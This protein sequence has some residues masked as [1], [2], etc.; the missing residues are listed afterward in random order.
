MNVARFR[1]MCGRVHALDRDK[2]LQYSGARHWRCTHC[3]RRFV[4][5]HERSD[6][7]TPIY[8]D[9]NARSSETLETGTGAA[10]PRVNVPLPPPALDFKCR[11]GVVNTVHSFMYGSTITCPSCRTNILAT[12]RYVPKR[13]WHVIEPQYPPTESTVRMRAVKTARRVVPPGA[14]RR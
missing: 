9:P 11:C 8:V 13:A 7:F 2:V 4:L 5:I 6:V 14:P 1:C 10:L 12:L 3:R